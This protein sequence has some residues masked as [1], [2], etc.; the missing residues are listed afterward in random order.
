MHVEEMA[1]EDLW[2]SAVK[3]FG[4]A[5][6]Y[7]HFPAKIDE[8]WR[9]QYYQAQYLARLKTDYQ[10]DKNPLYLLKTISYSNEAQ[11]PLPFWAH[12]ILRDA[13]LEF[14]RG[15]GN[16]TFDEIIG[17]KPG[18]GRNG[19]LLKQMKSE[20]QKWRAAFS[21]NEL[22]KYF[23]FSLP[24]TYKLLSIGGIES[25]FTY[26][27]RT[28]LSIDRL[29][30]IYK[31]KIDVFDFDE[32]ESPD[33]KLSELYDRGYAD[34]IFINEIVLKEAGLYNSAVRSLKRLSGG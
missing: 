28:F 5:E 15:A 23:G 19:H 10:K 25:D 13:A 20:S 16:I 21:I 9:K 11:F 3:M 30:E 4:S 12:N 7:P 29:E 31:S 33:D 17:L 34:L 2:R 24:V 18:R 22:H 8:D 14:E 26:E 27:P 6:S 32:P 1:G